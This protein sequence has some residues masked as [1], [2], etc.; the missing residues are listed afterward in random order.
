[1]RQ[2]CP[3]KQEGAFLKRRSIIFWFDKQSIPR[4]IDK[5]THKFWRGVFVVKL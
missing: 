4:D 5:M 3:F 1:M 2:K